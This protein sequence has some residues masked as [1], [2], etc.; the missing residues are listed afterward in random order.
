MRVC[1]EIEQRRE[2]QAAPNKLST[3]M[4]R[5]ERL[6]DWIGMA[7][8]WWI[9][10]AGGMTKAGVGGA[11]SRRKRDVCLGNQASMHAFALVL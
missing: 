9:F 5:M 4:E 7:D 10:D 1:R 2:K 6:N 8:G 11:N 3:G